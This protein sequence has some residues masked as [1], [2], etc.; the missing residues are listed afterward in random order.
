M[1]D[2]VEGF[3]KRPPLKLL[4]LG[5]GVLIILLSA[6]AG[7]FIWRT[8]TLSNTPKAADQAKS[9]E[10]INK[11]GKIFALPEGEQPTVGQITDK[12]K[13]KDQAFFTKA[14]TGDYLLVYTTEK[15]ALIYREKDNKIINAG[16]ITPQQ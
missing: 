1:G 4:L 10:I 14:E 13:I 16:P 2:K 9:T 12:E 3:K 11:V 5:A 6:V 15:L 7:Y 8:V